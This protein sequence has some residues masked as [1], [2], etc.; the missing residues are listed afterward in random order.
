MSADIG[1]ELSGGVVITTE[2]KTSDLIPFVSAT[3]PDFALNDGLKNNS[4]A[5]LRVFAKSATGAL[6]ICRPACWTSSV[7]VIVG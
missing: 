5:E 7:S 6:A 2:A 3:D 1:E 4:K